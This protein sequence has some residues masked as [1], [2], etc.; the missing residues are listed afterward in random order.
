MRA[1]MGAQ[2]PQADSR[3][4]IGDHHTDL[5]AGMDA[6]VR[7]GFVSYGFGHTDDLKPTKYFASFSEVVEY[8]LE[9]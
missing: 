9:S 4:M 7:T 1:L 3:R 6:N 5:V 8:F 2:G